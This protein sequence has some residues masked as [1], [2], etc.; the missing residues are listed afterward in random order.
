MK[1]L[2]AGLGLVLTIQAILALSAWLINPLEYT[3]QR[4][5]GAIIAVE[6]ILTATILY[7]YSAARED[8]DQ[9]WVV[10][11]LTFAVLIGLLTYFTVR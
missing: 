7:I 2:K 5:F 10:C 9:E 11:G 6:F 1:N 3:A 8:Y 4:I